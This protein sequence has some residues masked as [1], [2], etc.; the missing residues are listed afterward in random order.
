MWSLFTAALARGTSTTQ[1]S[2]VNTSTNFV[3]TALLGLIIFAEA[4]PPLW[5]VGASLLVAGNVL[6]G[7]EQKDEKADGHVVRL[8]SR[9]GGDRKHR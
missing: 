4:L 5:W 2:I 7:S 1:V 8:D 3:L 9:D 6:V